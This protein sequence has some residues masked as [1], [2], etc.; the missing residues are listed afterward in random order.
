MKTLLTPCRKVFLIVIPATLFMAA[1]SAW[2]SITSQQAIIEGCKQRELRAAATFIQNE[3]QEQ[4][5]Q[6]AAKASIVVNLPSVK[7]AFRAGNRERMLDSLLPAFLIQKGRYGVLEGQFLT[8]PAFSFLRLH[9]PRDGIGEDVSSFREMVVNASKE[10]QPRK[11]IEIGRRGLSIRGVDLVKDAA[12]YIGS[13]EV[14]IS[15]MPVLENLKENTGFEAGA[16]VNEDMMNR[17]AT[18]LPKTDNERIIGGFRNVDATNWNILKPV[19]TPDR[20]TAPAEISMTLET[21]A[22]T[23][24]GIVVVPLLD[25]KGSNIG[26]IVAVQVFDVYRN[27]MNAANVSAIAFALLQV[28][29]IAGIVIVMINVMF[30]QPA[31]L[32]ERTK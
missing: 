23:D 24:Y 18:L 29:V 32:M 2:S 12:G 17:I 9:A 19:V 11:G 22:G 6:A 16:F 21:I 31:S 15:F 27:Q 1:I 4:M 13:F 10:H 26:S 30:V 14:G 25:Y 3:L 5:N 20:L 8:P 28:L 7:E